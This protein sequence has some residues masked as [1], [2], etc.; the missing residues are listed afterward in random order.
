MRRSS[1]KSSVSCTS[2]SVQYRFHL[3]KREKKNQKPQPKCSNWWVLHTFISVWNFVII[4]VNKWILNGV[5]Y[6]LCV[7]Y[8]SVC[9][10]LCFGRCQRCSRSNCLTWTSCGCTSSCCSSHRSCSSSG[11]Q[12]FIIV[13]WTRNYFKNLIQFVWVWFILFIVLQ[14]SV[15][16]EVRTTDSKEISIELRLNV[17]LN[18]STNLTI[19]TCH[20]FSRF[21][22]PNDEKCMQSKFFNI[23]FQPV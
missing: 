14:K 3:W 17:Q 18:D 21:K 20:C 8:F 1:N 16:T 19:V 9:Y 15:Y 23:L 4:L 11:C 13:S 6:K 5:Y 12:P 7:V 22:Y 2:S 10:C